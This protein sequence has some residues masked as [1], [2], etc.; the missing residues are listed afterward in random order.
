MKHARCLETA[1]SGSIIYIGGSN[2]YNFSEEGDAVLIASTF[3]RKMVTIAKTEFNDERCAS[4]IRRI[5][6]TD[7]KE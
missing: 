3:D 5:H 2:S 1:K 4:R 7:V 6:Q